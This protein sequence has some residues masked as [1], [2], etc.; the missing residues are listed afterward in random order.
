MARLTKLALLLVYDDMG[1]F[2]FRPP[3]VARSQG[4]VDVYLISKI[5]A[6]RAAGGDAGCLNQAEPPSTVSF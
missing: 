1:I 2:L 3:H 4:F 5:D 6:V